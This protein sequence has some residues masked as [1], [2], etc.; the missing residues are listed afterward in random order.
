VRIQL[1]AVV[2]RGLLM[3][4][5]EL[6]WRIHAPDNQQPKSWHGNTFPKMG[7]ILILFVL[8]S[9]LAFAMWHKRIGYHPSPEVFRVVVPN[10][11]YRTTYLGSEVIQEIA[12]THGIKTIIDLTHFKP[13][14]L[15]DHAETEMVKSLG[16]KRF[17]FHLSPNSINDPTPY[18]K[19]LLTMTD[20]DNQPILIHCV[21]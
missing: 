3:Y 19:A 2:L 10:K 7:I 18:I 15:K 17:Q 6:V 5:K 9:S 14:S 11:I 1:F 12:Q 13:G 21:Q 4:S 20:K 16:I 8:T